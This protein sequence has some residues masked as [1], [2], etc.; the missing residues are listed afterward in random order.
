MG[1]HLDLTVA[2]DD[3]TTLKLE[4]LLGRGERGAAVVAAPHP[5]YGGELSN[6][7]VAAIAEGLERVG[8][9][10]LRFNFRGTGRS[11]GTASGRPADADADFRAA[12][13]ALA[14]RHPGPYIGAGYSF[15]AAAALR[16]A[17]R[18]SRLAQLVL[19]APPLAMIDRAQ[20]AGFAGPS[21][22]L[23]GDDDSYAPLAELRR[24]FAGLERVQLRVLAGE[25]HFFA[26]GVEQLC[27]L[28]A[29]AVQ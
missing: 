22:L 10:P 9:A 2:A 18:D 6:P 11:A 8:V 21:T 7:V 29:Q 3:G 4:A 26:T 13:D 27:G 17:A 19:V 25:D 20:L 12:L 15:G 28:V 24:A 1:V 5:L 16:V 23:F 14:A